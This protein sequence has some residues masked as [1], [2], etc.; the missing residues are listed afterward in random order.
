MHRVRHSTVTKQIEQENRFEHD[1]VTNSCLRKV[2][3]RK[4][5]CSSESLC[6][7]QLQRLFLICSTVQGNTERSHAIKI[8]MCGESLIP[9]EYVNIA[10]AMPSFSQPSRRLSAQHPCRNSFCPAYGEALQFYWAEDNL[11]LSRNLINVIDHLKMRK[12]QI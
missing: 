11:H 9:C 2:W 12:T 10:L 6:C 8:Q 1:N 5:S 3:K 4:R 7:L